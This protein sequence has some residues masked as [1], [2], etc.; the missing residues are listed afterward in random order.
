MV[1][2]SRVPIIAL[3]VNEQDRH[4]LTSIADQGPWDVHF[5]ESC[6]EA[7]AV[8][9][10]LGAPVILFDRNWPGT[11]WRTAVE[12][13]A[14]SAHRACVVLVSGVADDYLFQELNRH[15]GYDILPK[16]LR[17]DNAARVV[18]LALSYWNRSTKPAVPARRS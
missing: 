15:G 7:G 12:N 8:A 4:V 11:E 13:L 18:K 9:N 3:V 10:Q 14:A 16:P 2:S 17:P 5:A 1:L 6:E